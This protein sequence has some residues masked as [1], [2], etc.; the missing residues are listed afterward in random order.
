MTS[1]LGEGGPR[2][3][4]HGFI[5]LLEPDERAL[6]LR[7]S[8]L[9]HQAERLHLQ[10]WAR[11]NHTSDGIEIQGQGED[12]NLRHLLSWCLGG[13]WDRVMIGMNLKWTRLGI[14]SSMWGSEPEVE[15]RGVAS[16]DPTTGADTNSP[17]AHAMPVLPRGPTITA[18]TTVLG[19]TFSSAMY[20]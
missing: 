14:A 1:G 2:F 15:G 13:P 18:V 7:M 20:T 10:G 9:T 8:L 3:R 19:G 4:L 6:G 12:K 11:L 16:F 5:Y 17:F